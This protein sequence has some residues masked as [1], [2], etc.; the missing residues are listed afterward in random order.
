MKFSPRTLIA[1]VVI[2]LMA[3]I[4]LYRI[5]I[6]KPHKPDSAPAH[7]SSART[8]SGDS[9]PAPRPTR[10][11]P[12]EADRLLQE[13]GARTDVSLPTFPIKEYQTLPSPSASSPAAT[14]GK[15]YIHIP[16]AGR[17]IAFEPNPLGEFP[18]I[19]TKINDTIGIRL[20]LDAVKPGTPVR[21]V[22]LDGGTFPQVQGVT[23]LMETAD[24]RGVAFE[25]ITSGNIGNHRILVQAQGKPS[26]I[27]TF[28]A[29]DEETWP[30]PTAASR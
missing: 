2:F 8:P 29:H 24:W 22:I 26:R 11:I 10:G 3:T 15:A 21:V 23:R 25:F 12:R 4:L 16:S 13:H 17:R 18:T 30:A 27:L 9:T 5:G 6:H 28:N 20:A 19:E 7:T 1:L 14:A